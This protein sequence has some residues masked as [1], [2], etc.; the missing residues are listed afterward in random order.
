[1]QQYEDTSVVLE[2]YSLAELFLSAL[3]LQCSCLSATCY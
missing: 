3:V 2:C 1:M